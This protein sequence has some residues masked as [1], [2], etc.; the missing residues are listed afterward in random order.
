MKVV[1]KIQLIAVLTFTFLMA[2]T[3]SYAEVKPSSYQLKW[4]NSDFST[5]MISA[6]LDVQN[7]E[8]RMSD[9]LNPIFTVERGFAAS[10]S[11]LTATTIS[12]KKLKIMETANSA[13]HIV[14]DHPQRIRIFYKVDLLKTAERSSTDNEQTAWVDERSVFATGHAL[15]IYSGNDVPAYI[16]VKTPESWDVIASWR[17]ENETYRAND[18]RELVRNIF[19][20]GTDFANV[21]LNNNDLA[22]NIALMGIHRDSA[23][24]V[25]KAFVGISE[26]FT[27]LFNHHDV[28]KF[29]IAV[30]P[31][32]ND[33]EAYSNSFASS[34]PRAPTAKDTVVWANSLAHEYFHY[35]AGGRI[36]SDREHYAERQWFTEGTAEYYAN[37]ALLR[38][39]LID[40]HTYDEILAQYLSIHTLFAT[41]RAYDGVTIKDAGQAKGTY[42]PGVYD[43]G[44]VAAFCLDGLIRETTNEE[45]SL[46]DVMR[47]LNN[48]YGE[49]GRFIQFEDIRSAFVAIGGEHTGS[50]IDNF[51]VKRSVMPIEQ[52][53]RR[54]GYQTLS[55]G[56]HVLI[57]PIKKI[58]S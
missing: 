13:W 49:T 38:T 30:L 22:L 44:V 53:A 27:D 40:K 52:C 8:L 57:E 1:R 14:G 48:D 6:E 4:T 39:N 17:K 24:I 36:T 15:F 12:G 58:A 20:T 51:I 16:T 46:D 41:N 9:H 3:P 10:V 29:I 37:K 43:S 28:D 7:S 55:D 32:E 42:R 56:Y 45:R 35:W 54:M 19:V 50:F 25:K 5:V 31:G 21:A 23:D 11:D 26:Y 34:Q 33:G 18:T 47:L 2:S